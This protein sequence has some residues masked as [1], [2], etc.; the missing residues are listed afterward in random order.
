MQLAGMVSDALN[1]EPIEGALVIVG[2]LSDLT[3]AAGNYLIED[4]P[5]GQLTANFNANPSSGQSPLTVD[6]FD[7]STENSN[8]VICSKAD[9]NTYSNNQVLIP[10]DGQLTLNISLSPNLAEGRCASY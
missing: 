2:G 1:G 8:T 4:V 9:Y 5:I 10:Q 6:F 3:D 7:Q